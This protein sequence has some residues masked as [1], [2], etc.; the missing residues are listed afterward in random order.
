MPGKRRRRHLLRH[1]C[2][3]H[4]QS[5]RDVG[6]G[7][8]G[9]WADRHAN[10]NAGQSAFERR[11]PFGPEGPPGK[12][13]KTDTALDPDSDPWGGPIEGPE[14]APGADQVSGG[15]PDHEGMRGHVPN[16]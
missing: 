4:R 13:L 15:H 3:G 2:L 10:V 12:R 6:K 16:D 1:E 9:G 7:G 5:G 11:D 8:R 14:I